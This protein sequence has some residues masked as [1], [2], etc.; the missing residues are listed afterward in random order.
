MN[1]LSPRN[2]IEAADTMP[3]P[4]EAVPISDALEHGPDRAIGR[5][6]IVISTL[7]RVGV[8]CSINV[9]FVGMAIGLTRHSGDVRDPRQLTSL[10]AKGVFRGYGYLY[11]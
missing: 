4:A 11:S 1:P 7:L 2:A 8:I 3:A 9:I 6:E 5:I 10:T